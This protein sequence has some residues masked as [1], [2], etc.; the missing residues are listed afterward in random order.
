MKAVVTGAAGMIGSN[1]VH[2]AECD[3]RDDIIA[4][5]DMSDGYKYR[6]LSGARISDYF[7][8]DDFYG[9]FARREFGRV[10]VVLHQ[11]ACSDTME[12][13]GRLM[14]DSN[15]RCSQQ[16]ARCLPGRR[17]RACCMPPRRRSTAAV[18]RLR[19]L[20]E[21]ERPLNVYGYS[22]LLFDN[23]VAQ[24]PGRH[25]NAGGRTCAISTSMARASSTRA[26]WPRWPSTTY[27]QF[28][29]QG[30]VKLFGD[31]GGYAAGEQLRD[32]VYVDDVVAVNLWFLEHPRGSG[33]FNLGTGRAQTFND[34]ARATVNACRAQREER[35]AHARAA[36]R[37]EADPV[38][39]L[40]AGPGWQVPVPHAGRPGGLARRR[41]RVAVR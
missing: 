1:L 27:D 11:G 13:N 36:G 14:L 33:V 18:P 34:V 23:V 17:A 29:E 2:G 35:G 40:S 24:P 12:H 37:P 15:Y 3:R 5:D 31:Y 10:D 19:E 28:R 16:S 21:F 26:A 4:V 41:L 32:F 22:K 30:Q 9:R 39:R 7:D 25:L 6:N 20:P 8:K 38:C